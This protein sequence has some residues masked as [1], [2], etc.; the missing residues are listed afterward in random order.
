MVSMTDVSSSFLSLARWLQ[1][2]PRG[3][4]LPVGWFQRRLTVLLEV[5]LV[6][7]RGLQC[8]WSSV[9]A[10][11]RLQSL[12][13]V[14]PPKLASISGDAP[15]KWFQYGW[16]R[17]IQKLLYSPVVRR[18]LRL[19]KSVWFSLLSCWSSVMLSMSGSL[20]IL[21]IEF[22]RDLYSERI[23]TVWDGVEL[24][25]WFTPNIPSTNLWMTSF[26]LSSST[27]RFS[28]TPIWTYTW[29]APNWPAGKGA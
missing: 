9:R 5:L 26:P 2:G 1:L 15:C 25:L 27:A 17:L 13:L 19:W 8:V 21:A 20:R 12:C 11:E 10:V 7:T 14:R 4:W 29:R 16:S 3:E 6:Y 22:Y 23:A 18:S 28:M 24:T